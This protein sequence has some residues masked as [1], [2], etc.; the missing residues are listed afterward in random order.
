MLYDLT[1]SPLLGLRF[2]FL[3]PLGKEIKYH[4]C[5]E[6]SRLHLQLQ[7]KQK[8][9]RVLHCRYGVCML[10]KTLLLTSNPIICKGLNYT[11]HCI[12][13][14]NISRPGASVLLLRPDITYSKGR[15][16]FSDQ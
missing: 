13:G 11:C 9:I 14:T 12:S 6:Q 2:H 7:R 3:N 1:V 5:T 8:S 10:Y 4:I 16:Y 15:L